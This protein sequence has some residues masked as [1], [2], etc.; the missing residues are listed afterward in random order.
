[1]NPALCEYGL[2]A[3]ECLRFRHTI[4]IDDRVEIEVV[5]V[6]EGLGFRFRVIIVEEDL[7]KVLHGMF[8]ASSA[9]SMF[10]SI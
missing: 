7:G 9:V 8:E 10:S 2:H 4:R 1:M 5:P 3:E 6:D